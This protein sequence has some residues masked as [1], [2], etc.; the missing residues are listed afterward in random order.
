[1]TEHPA[2]I[3]P[4]EGFPSRERHRGNGGNANSKGRDK[5]NGRQCYLPS[6]IQTE[7]WKHALYQDGNK[8]PIPQNEDDQI[9][10]LEA[11]LA[12]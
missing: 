4:G 1:M 8:D 11:L 3:K 2:R 12:S 5:F 7:E 10:K 9:A 6:K